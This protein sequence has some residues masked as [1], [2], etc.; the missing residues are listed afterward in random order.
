MN[1]TIRNVKKKKKNIWHLRYAVGIIP[2]YSLKK[3]IYCKKSEE[4]HV[5]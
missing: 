4:R 1:P 3:I 2:T 5:S